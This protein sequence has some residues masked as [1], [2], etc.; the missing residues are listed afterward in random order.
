MSLLVDKVRQ[1]LIGCNAMHNSRETAVE[2]AAAISSGRWPK[3]RSM[4]AAIMTSASNAAFS[5]ASVVDP[6]AVGVAR[7]DGRRRAGVVLGALELDG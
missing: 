7:G 4:D 1:S 3:G 5:V 2:I 6:A